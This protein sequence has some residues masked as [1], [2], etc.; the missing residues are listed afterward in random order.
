MAKPREEWG[1][2]KL[3][4]AINEVMNGKLFHLTD[5]AH[6]ASIQEHGLLSKCEADVRGVY[7]A[8]PGGNDLTRALDVQR[9]LLDYVFLGFDRSGVM[10]TNQ[11]TDRQRRPLMLHVDPNIVFEA[12]VRVSLGRSTR[13]QNV[14][15]MRAFYEMDWDIILLPELRTGVGG[16]ARWN[17]FLDYEILF[18]NC[19][20]PHFIIG[21]D[22]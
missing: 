4:R 8:H 5:W 7:P 6:V 22:T 20:P 9:G 15:T 1:D 10:P 19:V 2:Y 18:P 14:S 21:Y 11:K 13:S 12:G 16:P 17:S 3:Y